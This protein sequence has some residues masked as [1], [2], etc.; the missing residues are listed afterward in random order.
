M[1]GIRHLRKLLSRSGFPVVP[2][3]A[4]QYADLAE[5]QSSVYAG[6]VRLDRSEYTEVR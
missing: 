2:L 6:V 1:S 4:N 3:D 5:P